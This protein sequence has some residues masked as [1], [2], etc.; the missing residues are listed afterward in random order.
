MAPLPHRI[1]IPCASDMLDDGGTP[2]LAVRKDAKHLEH[3]KEYPRGSLVI[4]SQVP[5]MFNP[6]KIPVPR[7]SAPSAALDERCSVCASVRVCEYEC[8]VRRV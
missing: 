6:A 2:I 4:F 5:T 3:L 1:L 7:I 8:K